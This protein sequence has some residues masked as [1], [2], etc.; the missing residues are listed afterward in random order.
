MSSIEQV[1]DYSIMEYIEKISLNY[2]IEKEKIEKIWENN[3]NISPT[4]LVSISSIKYFDICYK[5]RSFNDTHNKVREKIIEN[6]S[7]IDNNYFKDSDFGS[8]WFKLKTSFDEKMKEICPL[9]SSYKIQHKAGRNFNY[10]FDIH[11]FDFGK[12]LIKTT[13]LEFKYNAKKVKET[14][15]FVSP[16]KPSQYLSKSFEEFYYLNY[17]ERLFNEYNLIVPDLKVYIK[18]VHSTNP[19]CLCDAQTLYYQGCKSSS[20]YEPDNKKAILFYNTCNKISNECI[21]KFISESELDIEKLNQYLIQSQD[22]KI[23]LLYKKHKFHLQ[24]FILDDYIIKSYKKDSN[25]YIATTKSNKKLKILLRWKN[26]NGIAFP[27][28]QIS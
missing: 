9:Y 19:K 24:T 20:R 5:R 16:V 28:F 13:K 11:F 8:L 21:I 15:Q 4:N 22:E 18:Q 17:L 25:R 27:A 10:D 26:G 3:E 14:P 7:Y 12:N 2:G 6:M 1:I 23:Y